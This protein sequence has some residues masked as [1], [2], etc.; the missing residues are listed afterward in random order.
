MDSSRA[1]AMQMQLRHNT[2]DLQDF[3]RDLETWES[4][5][6]EKDNSLKKQKPILKEVIL[7]FPATCLLYSIYTDCYPTLTTSYSRWIP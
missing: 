5:I 2:E 3:L 7:L 1:T 4:E 6:K